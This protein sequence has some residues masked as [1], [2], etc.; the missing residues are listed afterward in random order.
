MRRRDIARAALAANE[1]P[2]QRLEIF[3]V[4]VAFGLS[5]FGAV[6]AIICDDRQAANNF[7][8]DRPR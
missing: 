4:V 2:P 8:R 3:L 1:P 7:R 5:A 6:T